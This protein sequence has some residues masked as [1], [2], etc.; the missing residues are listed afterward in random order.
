M[1]LNTLQ[2]NERDSQDGADPGKFLQGPEGLSPRPGGLRRAGRDGAVLRSRWT[3]GRSAASYHE[4]D[5]ATGIYK[6]PVAGRVATHGL[7]IDGD[8][9]ADRQAHGGPDRAAYACAE[10]LIWWSEQLGR[11]VPPGSMGGHHDVGLEV[12]DRDGR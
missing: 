9:Q 6:E 1:S 7:N 11:A 2:A 10:N 5:I 8:D 4:R 12:A 3:L